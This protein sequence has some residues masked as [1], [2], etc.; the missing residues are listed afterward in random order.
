MLIRCDVTEERRPDVLNLILVAPPVFIKYRRIRFPFVLVLLTFFVPAMALDSD[1]NLWELLRNG[2]HVILMRH[3][4]APGTGDPPEFAL[5][6]CDTQRNLS[7]EGR[8]QAKRIGERFRTNGI[9]HALVFSSQWCR[10]LDTAKLLKLGPVSELPFLNSFYER[11]ENR[12]IQTRELRQWL[13]KQDLDT[14]HVLVT[15]QVNI[16]AFTDNFAGSG[17]MIIVRRDDGGKFIVVGSIETP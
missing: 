12:D 11:Y 17:E 1:Q 13:A 16:S 10:C 2:G 6:D 5:R 15:H 3:A 8:N 9:D 7:D 4:L 14:L